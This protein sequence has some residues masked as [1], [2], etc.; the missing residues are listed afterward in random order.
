MIT[1]PRDTDTIRHLT[2]H[3]TL[4]GISKLGCMNPK[5][6]SERLNYLGIAESRRNPNLMLQFFNNRIHEEEEKREESVR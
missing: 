3:V 1:S 6:K 4:V 2:E 5:I